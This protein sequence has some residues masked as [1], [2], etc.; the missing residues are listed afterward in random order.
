MFYSSSFT[1]Q[2]D[3]GAFIYRRRDAYIQQ[4]CSL[5]LRVPRDVLTT[6]LSEL[7]PLL[8]R[9]L[10]RHV[11]SSLAITRQMKFVCDTEGEIREK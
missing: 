2:Q 8:T 4:L 5:Q 7:R 10:L 6:A 9:Y 11:L 1:G 3:C